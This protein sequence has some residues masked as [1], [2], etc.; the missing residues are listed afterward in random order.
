MINFRSK[1]LVA[2]KAL[3]AKDWS[4]PK[5]IQTARHMAHDGLSTRQ[6]MDALGWCVSQQTAYRRLRKFNI[7]PR[8]V[9]DRAHRGEATTF[10]E[11]TASH[12]RGMMS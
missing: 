4:H 1:M 3:A 10:P 11:L 2:A 8:D 5:V 9:M 6:I 7:T 12:S